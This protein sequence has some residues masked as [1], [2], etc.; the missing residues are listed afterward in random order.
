MWE[1]VATELNLSLY[2][3]KMV[4]SMSTQLYYIPETKDLQGNSEMHSHLVPASYHRITASG[5]AQRLVNGERE[6]TIVQS[7]ISCI[8]NSE[9]RDRNVQNWLNV[10][11]DTAPT[12]YKLF[13]Q[14]IILWQDHAERHLQN[15]KHYTMQIT[16]PAAWQG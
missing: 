10:M 11:R 3:E 16:G 7:M 15:A 4:C 12:A 14:N 9:Q 1:S 8:K 2:S 13:V 5:S 6:W